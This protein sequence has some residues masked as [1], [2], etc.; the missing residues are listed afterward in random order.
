MLSNHATFANMP[1]PI[2]GVRFIHTAIEREAG[3]I[4]DHASALADAADATALAAKVAFF[5]RVN[6]YHTR[7]EEVSI[8]PAI[9]AKVQ[10]QAAAYVMDHE[11]ERAM[12]TEIKELLAHLASAPMLDVKARTRLGRQTAALREA[13]ALHIRKE[14]ELLVPLIDAH[15]TPPE[16][17]AMVGKVIAEIP[18]AEMPAVLPWLVGW[19]EPA[20][21][22]VYLRELMRVMPPPVFDA[23]AGW[24]KTSLPTDAWSD[25]KSRIPEL[26]A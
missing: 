1:G 6:G 23:A 14:N 7:G 8:F 12:F 9:E 19:L 16:Q 2:A 3:A 4:E 24:L 21:R 20:D 17:G 18:P 10:H 22:E 25:L 5:E 11:D 15:F 26:S 13:L